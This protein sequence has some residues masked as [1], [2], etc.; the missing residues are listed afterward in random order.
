MDERLELAEPLFELVRDPDLWT[1]LQSLRTLR[2]WF[3]RTND[4][5][6]ARRIVATYLERMSHEDQAVLRK[7]LSEGLYIMLDENLG[8]G[9]SLQKNI[10]ELPE[11]MRAGI[12][13]ARKTLE[14]DVLLTPVL[15]ALRQ[16]DNLQR[17]GVLDAFDGSFFKGRFYARQPSGMIDVGNDREF[18]FLH[19]PGLQE[20][21]AAFIPLL[22]ADLPAEPRRQAI[23]LASFFHVPAQSRRPETQ[24]LLLRRLRDPDESVRAV[25]RTVVAGELD[26]NGAERDPER[27]DSIVSAMDGNRAELEAI[28]GAIGRTER[29]VGQPRIMA[30]IRR[31]MNHDVAPVLLPVLRWPAV[32]DEE[33]L[34]IVIRAWP[35]LAQ[36]QRLLAIEAMLA[37]SALVDVAN[38]RE[39]VMQIL[40]QGVTDPSPAVR[41]R[42]L[43]GV[44]ALEGLWRGKGSTSLVLAALADDTPGLRKLGLT[45]ASTKP[46]FWGRA[47]AR[48]Y[49][50]R[51]LIDPDPEIRLAAL[52][53]VNQ[54]SLIRAEP[55]LARRVKALDEDPKLAIRARQILGA[56]GIDPASI[57]ADARLVRPRLL[58]LATFRRKVFPLFYQGGEDGQSCARCHANHTILRIAEPNEHAPGEDPL[59]VNYNSALK[60]V[61]LG[62]PESSLILRKPRSPQGQGGPDPSSLTGLTHVGGPRWENTEHPAY[63]AILDWVREA[64]AAA[65]Q[66]GSERL[67]ADSFSPGYEPGQAGDGDLN[68]IWHT[69]FVGAMP[70]YPHELVIDLG[71]PRPIEG[72]LYVPRQD[73]PNGRVRD[74][75]VSVSLDG[76]SWGKPLSRGRWENDSTFKHVALP[77][78]IARY[79][80]LRGLS[81][82]EGRPVMSAAELAVETAPPP[83]DRRPHVSR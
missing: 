42:T 68:T 24:K 37:R 56:Q 28:L 79:V 71:T 11:G 35:R 4:R 32:G 30:V 21:E 19:E 17:A 27:M 65:A 55:A 67:S 6:F 59:I 1:R 31:L 18:G 34:S 82:V 23:Q 45:L 54:H 48:E 72:I 50:K 14:R 77:T 60:V 44:N 66:S 61:N 76:K 36:P 62:D 8:G 46:G 2:Q 58:S 10:S 13:D 70:G 83:P 16:G 7:N 81:E 49:L 64:S 5:D 69:E 41:E 3:Y 73:S 39:Q 29:L 63:R 40:R 20:L 33:V 57:E 78:P 74:F 25:A 9:V 47:D 22:G 12:L 38:P 15:G 52:A 53:A 43:R 80:Q 51:L 26:L 75:E